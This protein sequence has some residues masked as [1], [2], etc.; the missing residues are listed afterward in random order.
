MIITVN[1]LFF[2]EQK[3]KNSRNNYHTERK[4]M[5]ERHP[6]SKYIPYLNIWCTEKFCKK[7]HQPI[8]SEKPDSELSWIYYFFSFSEENDKQHYSFQES[9]EEWC[10]EITHTIDVSSERS[11]IARYTHE[12]TIDIIAYSSK[13]E[14][15]RHYPDELVCD[16]EKWF[17]YFLCSEIPSNDNTDC[18]PMK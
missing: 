10:W 12:F 9:L 18:S 1:F 4:Y 2:L 3:M 5:P 7:S 8:P 15:N 11:V 6:S 13:K 14:T 17:F 16:N